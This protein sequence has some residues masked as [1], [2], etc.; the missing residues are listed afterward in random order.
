MREERKL[1]RDVGNERRWDRC[2]EDGREEGS[3][4]GCD[5][6]RDGGSKWWSEGRRQSWIEVVRAER[7]EES[8]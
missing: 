1:G 8:E 7:E 6:A 2:R 4:R 3:D 5:G